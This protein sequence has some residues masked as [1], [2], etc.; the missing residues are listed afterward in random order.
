M[1]RLW[2]ALSEGFQLW[3]GRQETDDQKCTLL[4]FMKA[5]L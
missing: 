3:L 5:L 1:P 4:D 2:I